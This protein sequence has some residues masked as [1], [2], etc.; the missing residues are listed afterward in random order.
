MG[1]E[2]STMVINHSTQ[3]ILIVNYTHHFEVFARIRDEFPS[4]TISDDVFVMPTKQSE[5]NRYQEHG[6][7]IKMVDERKME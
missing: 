5:I 2:K 6:Y 1:F 7:Y 3:E 4:W